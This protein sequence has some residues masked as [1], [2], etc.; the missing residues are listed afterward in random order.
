MN[1]TYSDFDRIS[2]TNTTINIYNYGLTTRLTITYED[3]SSGTVKTH[4]YNGT[5]VCFHRL[6]KTCLYLYERG[7]RY[8][9]SLWNHAFKDLLDDWYSDEE[10]RY[11]MDDYQANDMLDVVDV[12]LSKGA[13]KTLRCAFKMN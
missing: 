10:I 6:V 1:R 3:L 7:R 9:V 13:F 8:Q 12:L 11:L 2:N 5:R 4:V